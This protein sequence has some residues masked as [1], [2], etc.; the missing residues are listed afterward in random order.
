VTLKD[1][2]HEVF[3]DT[4]RESTI[5]DLLAWLDVAVVV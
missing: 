1:T 5:R 2:F 3:N 4:G